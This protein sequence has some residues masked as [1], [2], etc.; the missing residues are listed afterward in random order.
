LE[1]T[2]EELFAEF[3]SALQ[4][5]SETTSQLELWTDILQR[6]LQQKE[7]SLFLFR[8]AGSP[9]LSRCIALNRTFITE[10]CKRQYPDVSM[11]MMEYIHTFY[12]W[13]VV[14]II[15]RWVKTGCMETPQ[16]IAGLITSLT[17]L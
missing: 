17:D 9:F 8:D 15:I 2:E 11:A 7:T 4:S 6:I 12:E 3:A 10:Q 5:V 1:Q 16:A 13:G 14:H